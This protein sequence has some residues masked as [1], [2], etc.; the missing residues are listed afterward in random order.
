MA[1]DVN[2]F[3]ALREQHRD[4]VTH[5]LQSHANLGI[6][7][8][9]MLMHDTALDKAIADFTETVRIYREKRDDLLRAA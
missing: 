9:E 8:S 2:N 1:F 3:M 7:L 5:V 6:G 4:A